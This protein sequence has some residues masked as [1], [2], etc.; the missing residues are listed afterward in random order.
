MPD[1]PSFIHAPT[2]R[3]AALSRG[4]TLVELAVVLFLVA[5]LLGA[6]L[7]PVSLRLEA[8]DRAEAQAYLETA[9]QALIGFALRNGRM[10]CPDVGTDGLE[11]RSTPA[12]P[13]RGACDSFDRWLP[14]AQLGVPATDPWGHRLRY[15][16]ATRM[17]SAVS[18]CPGLTPAQ[19]S[20]FCSLEAAGQLVVETRNNV[21]ALVTHVN[22]AAVVLVSFGPSDAGVA[23]VGSDEASNGGSNASTFASASIRVRAPNRV[24][25]ACNDA[26][27]TQAACH[28][29][30]IVD[31]IP[32]TVLQYHLVTAGRLP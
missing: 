22:A 6:L 5:L 19:R 16:V 12:C 18:E 17:V 28:F 21:R 24:D 23:R 4:F 7:G 29:D 1:S 10:P 2:S 15:S 25:Q 11:N 14:H 26:S 20:E 31:W 32:L 13:A 8:E 30:D 9:K 27:T 3:S